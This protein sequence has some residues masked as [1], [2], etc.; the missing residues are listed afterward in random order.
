MRASRGARR[1]ASPK[2]DGVEVLT[3]EEVVAR[4]DHARLDPRIRSCGAALAFDGDG[5]LWQGD[6]GDDFFQ[7]VVGLGRF[8]PAAVDAMRGVGRACGIEGMDAGPHAGVAIARRLFD[9]YIDQRLPED[10]ICEVVAWICAGWREE[11]VDRLAR[12]VVGGQGFRSRC[13][14]EVGVILEWARSSGV[15]AFVASASPRPVVEAAAAGL[16]FDR[17]HV[18]AVTPRYEGG[19]MLPEVVRPIPYGAGKAAL[20][21]HTLGDRVLVAA[22]GDNV[23]DVPMLEA[24]RLPVLVEP[25]RRLLAH[26]SSLGADGGGFATAPVCLR[27]TSG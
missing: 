11:E 3:A 16:G 7:A 12:D 10:L 4:L 6:V 26:L 15:A 21:A 23:F 18:L 17:D 25:K 14:P 13:H 22:F 8:L 27:V 1:G 20:L 2:L 5:T 19:V 24:A 9:A